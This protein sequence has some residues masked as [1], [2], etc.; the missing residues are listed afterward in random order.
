VAK[1]ERDGD[2]D[3][4]DSGDLESVRAHQAPLIIVKFNSP[5]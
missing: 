1:V 3:H 2:R 5:N 4:P